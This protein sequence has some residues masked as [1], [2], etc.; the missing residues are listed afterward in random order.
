M[1]GR[2]ILA[3]TSHGNAPYLMAARLAGAMGKTPVVIPLYYGDVQRRIMREELGP[4]LDHIYL[5]AAL[6]DLMRPLLLDK[7]DGRSFVDFASTLADDR[8]PS[9]LAAVEVGL[10]GLLSTGIPA[11]NLA[12][13]SL[14]IFT[15][16]DF[17]L[18][19]NMAQPLLTPQLRQIYS[20]TGLLSRIYGTLPPGVEDDVSTAMVDQLQPFA[21]KWA[22]C[23]A[24]CRLRFV[25]RIHACSYDPAPLPGV[26]AIPPLAVKRPPADVV[27]EPGV[28]FSP[29]GT[30]TDADK[31]VQ[32]AG[33]LAGN[34][35]AYVLAGGQVEKQFL[36]AGALATSG[37]AYADGKITWVAARGGWGTLWECLMHEKPAVLVR[38]TFMEDPEMG[39]TQL[40]MSQLGLAKIYDTADEVPSAGEIESIRRRIQSERAAD[41]LAFGALADD[42]YAYLAG[43][44]LNNVN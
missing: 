1:N 31:L 17:R 13:G 44:I 30:G 16:E 25:P 36:S 39:H 33:I 42:G 32:L 27:A 8:N 40:S 3:I 23:E 21:A 28:L 26:L 41:R 29:S 34:P 9:G 6:G 10:N 38:T 15:A 22:R 35:R 14:R 18:A 43:Q 37:Q 20:F 24:E 11:E 7:S 12:D 2:A 19:L 4:D 5:S